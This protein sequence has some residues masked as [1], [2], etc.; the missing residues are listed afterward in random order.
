[1]KIALV[2]HRRSYTTP[3]LKVVSFTLSADVVNELT[4][5]GKHW[6]RSRSQTAEMVLRHGLAALPD[7]DREH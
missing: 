1:M 5:L 4:R 6:G 3:D 2:R 7:A